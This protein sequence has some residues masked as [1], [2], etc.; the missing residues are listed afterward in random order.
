MSKPDLEVYE[1]WDLTRPLVAPHSVLFPLEPVGMGTPM[2]ESLTSYIIRLAQAHC[3]APGTLLNKVVAPLVQH[4]SP[5]HSPHQ[6]AQGGGDKTN[7]INAMGPRAIYATQ[8]LETLTGRTDLRVL[9]LL[10]WEEV[11]SL[12]GLIR[13]TKAWCPACYETWRTAGQVI[14]DPLLWAFREVSVCLHHR[15]HLCLFCPRQQCRRPLPS[16]S[17]RSQPGYCPH[18]LCW[19]GAPL[20][21]AQAFTPPLGKDET[22]WQQWVTETLGALLACAPTVAVPPKRQRVAETLQYCV[23]RLFENKRADLAQ[24]LGLPKQRVTRV[25]AW[26]TGRTLPEIGA[27][28]RLCCALDLS[29][30][31]VLV[32]D[33]ETLQPHRDHASLKKSWQPQSNAS[34]RSGHKE[35][36]G[37]LLEQVLAGDEYPPPSVATVARRLNCEPTVLY[38]YYREGCH[39]LSARHLAYLHKRRSEREYRQQ[40]ELRQAVFRLREEGAPLTRRRIEALLSQPA[41]LRQPKM[42]EVLNELWQE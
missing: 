15:L 27:L 31:E 36:L 26:C 4:L 8:A 20:E 22:A 35:R 23:E 10:T 19:L 32:K 17:W 37:Q 16:L 5:Q 12:R 28:L 42:R 24:F 1:E 14:Y 41:I 25:H 9:T 13:R 39:I 2:V 6:F 38:R 29:L 40:E 7:L 3:V 18:C 34:S 11:L 33:T 30:A 21:V